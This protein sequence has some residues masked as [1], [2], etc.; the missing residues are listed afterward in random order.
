VNVHVELWCAQ[1]G[2][3]EYLAKLESHLELHSGDLECPYR[4][5]VGFLPLLNGFRSGEAVVLDHV[6]LKGHQT[7]E[8]TSADK[9]L[10]AATGS[11]RYMRM[12]RPTTAS[13]ASVR[14]SDV[15]QVGAKAHLF[16]L[17]AAQEPWSESLDG[18]AGS[19]FMC[20]YGRTDLRKQ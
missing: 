4:V 16:C 6:F 10:S 1:S 17:R 3:S 14:E 13:T 7:S 15:W 8:Q 18:H 11:G 5:P 2:L 9:C 12:N 19:S 20:T